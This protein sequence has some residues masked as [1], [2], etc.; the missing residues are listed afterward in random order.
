MKVAVITRHGVPN[1]GS[2]LQAIATQQIFTQLGCECEII[3]YIR[4]DEHYSRREY[5]LLSQKKEWKNNIIKKAV[6]LAIR[7]PESIFAGRKFQKEQRNYL[8]LSQRYSSLNELKLVPPRADIYVTGSDQV[9]GK[10]ENGTYD[11]TYCLSFTEGTKI[12]YAASFGNVTANSEL[13]KL[14]KNLLSEYSCVMVREEEAV[15][16]L[17]SIGIASKQVLDPTLVLGT[18]FW[19]KYLEPIRYEDYILIYQ[20]HSDSKLDKIAEKI[21]KMTNKKLI[22]VSATFHQILRSGKFIYLPSIG[23][24]LSYIKNAN[25]L[26]TDSFHG[27]AFAINFNVP[28]LEILPNSNTEERNKSLLRMFELDKRIVSSIDDIVD[29]IEKIDYIK[30]NGILNE[31]RKQSLDFLSNAILE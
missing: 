7:Q 20:I 15:R 4:F 6:Y 12:S 28:F 23:Q 10:T 21:A 18:E 14:F 30:V 13:N 5:T 2:L 24:F 19:N 29:D 3:D 1:Y 17:D 8:N 11:E 25:M 26:I 22:R 27:T 16:Y 9:W 31:N